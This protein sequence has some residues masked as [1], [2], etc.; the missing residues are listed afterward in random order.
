[1]FLSLQY[2]FAIYTAFYGLHGVREHPVHRVRIFTLTTA[3]SVDSQT[4]S[5]TLLLFSTDSVFAIDCTPQ[6]QISS[7]LT[8]SRRITKALICY[9][10]ITLMTDLSYI[11]LSLSLF[12]TW[13]H[14]D[15]VLLARKPS[16]C[17]LL[18]IEV[19]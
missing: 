7:K 16:L 15:K 3:G 6:I 9:S 19:S 4:V 2:F 12:Q 14:L 18:K 11:Y 10:A 8:L 1:M 5:T 13:E 17:G